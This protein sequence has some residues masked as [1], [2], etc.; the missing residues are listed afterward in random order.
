MASPFEI[1][2]FYVFVS[3]GCIGLL[4]KWVGDGM[5]L[6]ASTI[7]QMAEALMLHGITWLNASN[8]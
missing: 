6:P 5:L 3:S 4:R 1:E 8:Q 7:A 2:Y